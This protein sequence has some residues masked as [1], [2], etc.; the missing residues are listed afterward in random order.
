VTGAP[1]QLTGLGGEAPE[2]EKD[3]PLA[4]A[5][6]AGIFA[7]SM[8]TL[9]LSS[10]LSEQIAMGNRIGRLMKQVRKP[11]DAQGTKKKARAI[12]I[13]FKAGDKLAQQLESAGIMLKAEEFILL[14]VAV[15]LIPAGLILFFGVSPVTAVG[16]A[17]AGAVIPPLVVS[18]AR[19]KRLA[20]F[21][22]QLGDA[23]GIISNCLRS[24]FSFQQAMESI[25]G[26]MAEPISK[27]FAKTLR[28]MRLGVPIEQAMEN[29][30]R[31]MQNQDLDM[32]V[33]AVLIQRQV[34][35]N[36]ADIIDN[37]SVTIRDRLKI[38]GDVK[39]LAASGRISGMVIGL[40]GILM[41]LNPTY[42]LTFF[43]TKVGIIMLCVAGVMEFTGFFMVTKIVDIKF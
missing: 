30:V 36:L 33:S 26:E 3:M 9:L 14:W 18:M 38:K 2:K 27:E 1:C 11:E 25:S 32:L 12:K 35:G 21:E 28:E 43:Q 4:I 23:L 8:L 16:F 19:K 31:R 17:A 6:I 15:T 34:G 40:M 39:V 13:K 22:K 37:I 10:L 24:G 7:F 20:L 41:F 5:V 29:I 42:V